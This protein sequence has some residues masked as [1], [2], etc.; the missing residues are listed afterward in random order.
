MKYLAFCMLVIACILLAGCTGTRAPE[1][2]PAPTAAPVTPATTT[3]TPQPVFKLGDSY[4]DKPNGYTFNTEKDV[5]TE[6][7]R[8]DTPSWGI[9]FKV[10]PLNENLQSCWFTMNVTNLDNG[11]T[12]TFGYGGQQSFEL[13]QTIPMYNEGPYKITMK[14]N[15]VKVWM[16]ASKRMP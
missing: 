16:K 9:Y 6:E 1:A 5:T 7:F 3:P 14:G 12:E 10:K 15:C 2:T 13:E 4:V 8:V 11:R